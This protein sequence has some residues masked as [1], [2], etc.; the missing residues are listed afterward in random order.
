MNNKLEIVLAAKDVT[1]KAFANVSSRI[2]KLGKTVFSFRGAMAGA[3]GAAG[4]GLLIK[5]QLEAA[6]SI[7]KVADSIG[8]STTALQE[9]RFMADRSGVATTMLDNGLGAFSKRLGELKAGTGSLYGFLKKNNEALAEQ[10]AATTST[11][12]ALAIFLDHLGQIENQADKTALSAAAFSR[13]AGIKMTNLVKG[14]SAGLAGMRKE[15]EDL[16]LAIDEKYL[17]EAEAAV[18]SF[19]NLEYLIRARLMGSIVALAPEITNLVGEFTGWVN[20]NEALIRQNLPGYMDKVKTGTRD[21]FDALGHIKGLYDGLPDEIKGSAGLGLVGAI[22]FGPK[23]GMLI[24]GGSFLLGEFKDFFEGLEGLHHGQITPGEFIGDE[25]EFEAAL[26][27][28]RD[29][30]KQL[31]L[32]KNPVFAEDTWTLPDFGKKPAGRSTPVRTSASLSSGGGAALKKQLDK[33]QAA[34]IAHHEA[35]AADNQA[36]HE[37]M[38]ADLARMSDLSALTVY[39]YSQKAIDAG[40]QVGD[41]VEVQA[42]RTT[43]AFKHAFDG[44]ANDFSSSLNDMLWGADLTFASIAESFA[45]M[46]T[47]MAIQQMIVQPF[48]GWLGGLGGSGGGLSFGNFD[49]FNLISFDT[50][51][52]MGDD[53]KKKPFPAIVHS[54]E[55][56]G[57]P[58]QM[59]ELYGGQGDGSGSGSGSADSRPAINLTVVNPPTWDDYDAYMASSRGQD[60]IV[61]GVQNRGEQVRRVLR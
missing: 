27:R 9:Y 52:M 55:V 38:Y 61:V 17:R 15:F 39:E 16:G 13:T 50:G 35:I 18:D 5:S 46:V 51:G 6:D 19:T 29:H 8:I 7:A 36:T 12:Q 30:K 37:K 34:W 23:G 58:K 60:K 25:R 53:G 22:M 59:A 10:L 14:G 4:A 40:E 2:S 32:M 47:E 45:K 11:D 48:M 49:P 20:Q 3:A 44:W 54:G 24:G 31:E 1:G 42:D 41:Q 28:Y 43:D 57:T 33:E 26:E 56:I 21:V